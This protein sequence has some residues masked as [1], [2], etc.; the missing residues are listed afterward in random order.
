MAD[1]YIDATAGD[2]TLKIATV[3]DGTGDHQRSVIELDSSGTPTKLAIGQQAKAASLP[4]AIASDQDSLPVIIQTG[5]NTIGYVGVISGQNIR[6]FRQY[7]NDTTTVPSA[8]VT[9]SGNSTDISVALYNQITCFLDVTAVSG[10]SP[11]LDIYVKS[12]DPISGKYVTIGQYA[13]VTA[14]GTW[15]LAIDGSVLG[16]DVQFE[17]VLGGTSPS[18]TFS[19]GI[20]LK[21]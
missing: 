2:G 20:V 7:S 1:T 8:T 21:G 3:N 10:T 11:T 14:T 12:K 15:Q 16:S 13:Q 19:I 18:F 17:W 6:I 5:G 9:A 4:V